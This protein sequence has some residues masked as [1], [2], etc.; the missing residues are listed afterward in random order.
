MKKDTWVLL[1]AL[2]VGVYVL[3]KAFNFGKDVADK[4]AGKIADVWLSLF[5]LPGAIEL[6]GTVRFPGGLFVPLQTLAQQGGVRQDANHNVFVKYAGFTWQ[7]SPQVNGSWPA[8]RV[9]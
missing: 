5:P 1:A 3:S 9:S 4:A 7:L 6:V 8:T 2:G